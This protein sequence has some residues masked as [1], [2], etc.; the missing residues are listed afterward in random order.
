MITVS[1][2]IHE[3]S[4]PVISGNTLRTTCGR[5]SLAALR[6][7]YRPVFL[8]WMRTNF[9][10]CE[11]SPW[12]WH[13][14]SIA[15]HLAVAMLLGLLAWRLLRDRAAAVLA[16]TLFAVHPAQTESV[17]WVTV[18]DPLMSAG[19]LGALLLYLRHTENPSPDAAKKSGKGAR[20]KLLPQTSYVWLVSAAAVYFGALLAKETAIVLPVAIFILAFLDLPERATLIGTKKA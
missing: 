19:V 1:P 4:Q 16:A 13:L 12:G 10:L 7:Y 3:S 6:V 18:P 11:L 9:I 5:N 14:L 20:S 8:L 17:A 2:L 15:K